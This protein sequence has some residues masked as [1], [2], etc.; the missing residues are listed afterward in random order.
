MKCPYCEKE[1]QKGEIRFSDDLSAFIKFF[2]GPRWVSEEDIE[3]IIP[4]NTV[5]L[6]HVAETYYCEACGKAVAYF[7][8]VTNE[9]LF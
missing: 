5:Q 6:S 3:R 7:D 8:A 4:K 2:Q 9:D 1:M